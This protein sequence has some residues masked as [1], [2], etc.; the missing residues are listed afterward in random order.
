MEMEEEAGEKK[1]QGMAEFMRV[2]IGVERSARQLSKRV[3]FEELTELAYADMRIA[4]R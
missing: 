1:K 2:V 4:Y 3:V